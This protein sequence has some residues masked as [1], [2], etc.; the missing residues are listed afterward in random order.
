MSIFRENKRETGNLNN[1]NHNFLKIVNKTKKVF[2]FYFVLRYN[3]LWLLVI[4]QTVLCVIAVYTG[5]TGWH[6]KR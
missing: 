1:D 2:V 4:I 6:G 5:R 3:I